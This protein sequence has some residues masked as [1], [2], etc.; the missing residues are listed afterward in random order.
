[1]DHGPLFFTEI[2]FGIILTIKSQTIFAK[3]ASILSK[4]KWD[5]LEELYWRISLKGNILAP[6]R[7]QIHRVIEHRGHL[8]DKI[9]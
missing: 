8:I 1:M 4:V 5:K 2:T 3:E 7:V 9:S 6:G